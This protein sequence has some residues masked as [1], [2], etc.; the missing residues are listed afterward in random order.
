MRI[1]VR[2]ARRRP[3]PQQF[4]ED[5]DAIVEPTADQSDSDEYLAPSGLQSR[6]RMY[7]S[8]RIIEQNRLEHARGRQDHGITISP[9][10]VQYLV[11]HG[12]L[13]T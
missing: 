9:D 12:L 3:Q 2:I 13:R 11:Q 6:R 1:G 5:G 7:D 10:I 8:R 4:D